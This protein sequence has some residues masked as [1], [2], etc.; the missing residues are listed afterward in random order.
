MSPSSGELHKSNT[1]PFALH[2]GSQ[3]KSSLLLSTSERWIFSRGG[4]GSDSVCVCT[5]QLRTY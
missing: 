2:T 1:I 4:G 3:V 5:K